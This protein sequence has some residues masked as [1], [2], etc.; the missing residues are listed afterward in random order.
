MRDDFDAKAKEILARRVGYRC[1]NPDCGKA[2]S[3]PQEDPAKALNIGVAAHITAASEGG[4]RYD[5]S[6]SSEERRSVDNGLWLCQNC[7]KLIDSDVQRYTPELLRE[8]KRQAEQRALDEVVGI[9]YPSSSKTAPR[10]FQLPLDLPTF[11]GRETYLADLDPL[12]QPGTGQTVSLVG[13]RGTAGVGKSVLA[14]HAAHRWGDRFRDG[15]VWVDLRQRD[16]MSALRHVAATYG[17]GDQAAQIPDAE[18]LAALVRS[19]LRGREALVILDNAEKVPADEFPLL[20][21]GVQGCVTLVT[22]RRSFTELKRYGQVLPVGEME[23]EEAEALLARIIG[24]TMDKDE[25]AARSALVERLGGLP[26][27][28]DIAARLIVEQEWSSAEYLARLRGAPSLVAELCLPLAERPEDSVAVAFALSY[29]AL[30]E[31]QQRLFRALGVMAE[32]GFAPSAV[33]GVLGEEPSQVEREMGDVEAL[34]LVRSGAVRGRYELHPLLADYSRTL[35]REAGEWEGLRNAHLA[36]YVG[37]AE[38]YTEDYGALEAEL[39]NLMAAGEWSRE[40]GEN[41]GVRAL[42]QW[43]YSGGV[44]FLDLRGHLREAVRLLGWGVEAARAM[45]NRRG[46]GVWQGNLGSAY[47]GLGE[48]RRA[49]EYHEQALVIAREIGDRGGEGIDLGNLGVAYAVLGEVRRAIEYYEQALVIDREIGDRGGEGID[50]GSLGL[51][52]ADLGEVG[53]AI[54]SYEQ[55]LAITREIGDRRNEGAWQGNLGSAYYRLGEVRRAIEYYEQALVISR[56]IGDRQAEG[57]HLGNLGLA[58]A[59]LGE[60]RRGIEYYEQALGIAR[61]IGDRRGE[62]T[63]LGNLG[64]AYAALGEVGRAIEYYEQ[65]QAIAREIGDRWGEGN[66]LGNL[67][68]AYFALGEVRRAMESY[69]QALGIAREIGDRRNE[70]V[71]LGNLGNAYYRLGEVRRAIEYYEQALKI[72]REIGDRGGEGNALGNLG[73]AYKDLGD[74]ARARELWEQALRIFEEIEDPRAE[75]VRGWL[76]ALEEGGEEVGTE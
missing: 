70:G 57:A 76:A 44:H 13:L 40:S 17:Y 50:L 42:A 23:Q 39:G 60:V 28:L 45:G 46:E 63:H 24:E 37:Y 64:L 53:R 2:T 14:V 18:G 75:Q 30:K 3:G 38:R 49:I 25:Q 32:G 54:E 26:L 1:S 55:A 11:T 74:L 10:P 35:A 58:Y 7:A 21:P 73:L 47:Y 61:E 8:W 5:P 68:V 48:V 56:E 43:L 71:H 65:A 41:E 59:A 19:V 29:E 15:V 31:G 62:G 52:Y 51:A 6:L 27:A 34:S 22:S 16:V 72:A 36:Y 4:P 67:G 12:L 33:A 66:H 9:V 20:L 69:E